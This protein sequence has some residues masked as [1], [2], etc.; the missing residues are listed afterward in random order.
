MPFFPLAKRVEKGRAAVLPF[1]FS[2]RF[3]V[4]E[5]LWSEPPIRKQIP[6]RALPTGSGKRRHVVACD[7]LSFPLPTASL[8]LIA[9]K[10]GSS[11]LE[12]TLPFVSFFSSPGGARFS[13]KPPLP[14]AADF[15]LLPPALPF[16]PREQKTLTRAALF[17][18]STDAQE[19]SL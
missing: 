8:G 4:G 10:T 16:D 15:S 6:A 19:E 13:L 7:L 1:F 9:A 12:H 11:G 17:F 3:E 14:A 2:W 18:S 5:V